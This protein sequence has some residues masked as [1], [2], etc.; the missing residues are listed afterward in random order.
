MHFRFKKNRYFRFTREALSLY[1][2]DTFA[3][4]KRH[5]RFTKEVLSLYKTGIFALQNR[6]FRGTTAHHT[7]LRD[8]PRLQCTF[9][10]QNSAGC[11]SLQQERIVIERMTPDRKLEASNEGYTAPG[12]ET[13]RHPSPTVRDCVQDKTRVQYETSAFT[14]VPRS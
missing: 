5:F 1:K 8:R 7:P 12:H 4:Q 2:I 14:G 3:L 13:C 11:S 6:H 10:S 9:A